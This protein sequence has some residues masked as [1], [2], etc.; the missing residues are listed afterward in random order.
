MK[1]CLMMLPM[2]IKLGLPKETHGPVKCGKLGKVL[3]TELRLSWSMV[4]V[5]SLIMCSFSKLLNVI[6]EFV[7]YLSYELMYSDLFM[8]T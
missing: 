7:H 8:H 1:M 6:L 5:V 3:G 2:T 4:C